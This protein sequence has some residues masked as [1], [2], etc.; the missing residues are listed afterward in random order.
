MSTTG[1]QKIFKF[2][3]TQHIKQKSFIISTTLISVLIAAMVVLINILPGLISS[4]DEQ[5]GGTATSF[6]FTKMYLVDTSDITDNTYY[7]ELFGD[8]EYVGSGDASQIAGYTDTVRN[9]TK[10]MLITI[11]ENDGAYKILGM[12]PADNSV[13]IDEANAAANTVSSAF[14]AGRL[15]KLGLQPD[16]IAT[17]TAPVTIGQVIAGDEEQT[18]SMFFLNMIVPMVTS[19]ILFVMII[20]Y[21]QIIAQSIALEKTSKVIELLLTSTKPLA[22][23]IGKVS[24]I[25][26]LSILQFLIF[27]AVGGISFAVTLPLGM[28]FG[29]LAQA[30]NAD[31]AQVNDAI[32]AVFGNISPLSIVLIIVIFLA[33]F[34]FYALVAGLVGASVSRSED[35]N[36]AMQPFAIISVLGLYLA[37]FPSFMVEMENDFLQTLSYYLPLSSPFALPAA[38]LTNKLDIAQ[39]LI[40]VAVLIIVTALFAVFVAKVYHR[41]IV[42]T[43]SRLTIKQIFGMAK[44]VSPKK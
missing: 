19:I 25:G 40:C 30:G 5:G 22:V 23:I 35:L 42:H 17:A 29:A 11:T 9:G 43:G 4:G 13:S 41:I 31:M 12:R 27:I 8:I 37:Y 10:C 36:S 32:N 20:S 33:G 34:L 38:I 21:G 7:S 28:G 1:W 3:F 44:E 18:E 24:A 26:L 39:T 15:A 14:S 6:S 16:T 2:T